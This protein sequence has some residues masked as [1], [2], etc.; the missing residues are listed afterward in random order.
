MNEAPIEIRD[1]R[2][3]EWF[4]GSNQFIDHYAEIV[5]SSAVSVYCVLC[6]YANNYTQKCWPS[7]ETIAKKSGLKSRKTIS[8]AI[9]VLEE[10]NIITV[11][12]K[13]DDTGK[14]SNNVYNL[15]S[16]KAWKNM[17]IKVT[18]GPGLTVEI[19]GVGKNDTP[20]KVVSKVEGEV[21]F[22]ANPWLNKEAWGEWAQHRKEKKV[23]L[24]PSAIKKQLKVL[25]ENQSDQYG[26]IEKSIMN[27]WQGLFPL[28]KSYNNNANTIIKAPEGKYDHVS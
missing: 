27:N 25:F 18:P 6:R 11:E 15:N 14:R 10:Y 16:P 12:K 17:S 9:E 26:I 22:A 28:K 5:G 13:Y 19:K 21:D 20:M 3:Q 24:T 2:E 4:W 8:A 1:Q 7:M 23:K